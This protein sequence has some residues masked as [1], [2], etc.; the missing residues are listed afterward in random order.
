MTIATIVIGV[1]L[2]LIGGSLSGWG[3]LM[4]DRRQAKKEMDLLEVEEAEWEEKQALQLKFD[5][6]E[7]RQN[8]ARE[9]R[10]AQ[11]YDRE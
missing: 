5:R 10:N 1:T 9:E 3:Q 6:I 8:A 4:W 11:R 2:A 7:A